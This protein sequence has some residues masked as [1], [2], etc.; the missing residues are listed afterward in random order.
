MMQQTYNGMP[1]A[2]SVGT[3]REYHLTCKIFIVK[4]SFEDYQSKG[5]FQNEN[6]F[7]YL[8]PIHNGEAYGFFDAWLPLNTGFEENVEI[9]ME[10]K[11][12]FNTNARGAV[13]RPT[14]QIPYPHIFLMSYGVSQMIVANKNILHGKEVMITVLDENNDAAADLTTKGELPFQKKK[15][16]TGSSVESGDDSHLGKAVG[17]MDFGTGKRKIYASADVGPRAVHK[18]SAQEAGVV[19]EDGQEKPIVTPTADVW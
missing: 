4:Q 5:K 8:I 9:A 14:P 2:K 10:M 1:I 18:I 16:E 13:R 15:Y 12:P 19:V 7:V 17:E 6:Y 3:E 11:H